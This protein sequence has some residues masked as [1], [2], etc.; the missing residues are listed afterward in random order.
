MRSAPARQLG[1]AALAALAALCAGQQNAAVSVVHGLEGGDLALVTPAFQWANA[2]ASVDGLRLV[3]FNEAWCERCA[4]PATDEARLGNGT[5]LWQGSYSEPCFACG[6]E[7][8]AKW[9]HEQGAAAL[10]W[11][12]YLDA[13]HEARVVRS[14][15]LADELAPLG[16]VA[17]EVPEE[18]CDAVNKAL[19][20]GRELTVDVRAGANPWLAF[21][22]SGFL[23]TRVVVMVVTFSVLLLGLR[24]LAQF[25]P[26]TLCGGKQYTATCVLLLE[27]LC[28]LLRG[29]YVAVD[30]F[31]SYY[32]LPYGL[33]RVVLTFTV[34]V[35]L[36]ATVAIILAWDDM[37]RATY[38]GKNAFLS[39]RSKQVFFAVAV[40]FMGTDIAFS[41]LA[42]FD[43]L[44]TLSFTIGALLAVFT[45]AVAVG[46][47]VVGRRLIAQ[48][49]MFTSAGA[50]SSGGEASERSD[51]DDT[52]GSM[53]HSSKDMTSAGGAAGLGSSMADCEQPEIT[54]K[55]EDAAAAA[56]PRSASFFSKAGKVSKSSKPGK[57]VRRKAR[58]DVR[59]MTNKILG[60]AFVLIA[61]A[62]AL[63][64]S[65]QN[66]VV[67]RPTPR[68][69][70]FGV[71]Y[72]LLAAGSFLRITFFISR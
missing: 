45:V 23:V 55:I 31:F 29:V 11:F 71:L 39:S 40:V 57:Q 15:A 9:S 17:V 18:S 27:V 58:A 67:F 47:I 56:P 37:L 41:F 64:F 20:G 70:G 59:Y 16:L 35:E 43:G 34:S 66:F 2:A 54:A 48:L 63:F 12:S 4:G 69:I 50:S 61:T 33:S 53:A 51:A 28:N 19:A 25:A 42:A 49:N 7:R 65:S 46:I 68:A 44:V 6:Y 22:D 38:M 8:I 62:V 36:V 1:G 3:R 26:R 10:L 24:R 72:C 13:G 5:A 52:G 14:F 60:L 21:Y 30:P 32:V